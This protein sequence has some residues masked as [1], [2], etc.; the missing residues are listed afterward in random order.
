LSLMSNA[1]F[2]SGPYTFA[3]TGPNGFVS[4][5]ENPVISNVTE[6]YNGT[7]DL[8]ITDAN[9]CVGTGNL[10][11]SGITNA[12]AQPVISTDGVICDGGV[13]QLSIAAYTGSSVDYAWIVPSS[14]N[15]TGINTNVL[16]INPVDSAIHEGNYVVTVT[17]DGCMITSDT[18]NLELHP[19]PSAAPT[20]TP[21]PMC[22]GEELNLTANGTG[23]S[24]YFWT[25]PNGFTSN[26][27][28]PV[29]SNI[30]IANNGTY[31]L[32]VTNITGCSTT[33]E[34]VVSNI[35]G[36]PV[37]P[38]ITAV[39]TVCTD[40]V[41]TLSIQQQYSGAV[42]YNWTNGVGVTIGT[43]TTVTLSPNSIFAISPYRV[44]VTVNGC[45]SLLSDPVEVIEESLP[46]AIATNGG[47]IC[48]GADGQLFA[49]PITGATYEWRVAGTAT[50]ISTAQNPIIPN[51]QDSTTFELT[52]TS[53]NGCVSNPLSYTEIPV[54]TAPTANPN[55]SYSVN[56]D[57]TPSD[58]TLTA[59]ATGAGLLYTW[60]G[61][62]G[63]TSNAEN[64]IIPNASSANN[65][66]YTLT[67]TTEN[68]CV[69]IGVT[70]VLIDIT[71]Q[72]AQ[73]IIA[74]SGP[75]CEGETIVLTVPQY[76]G[77]NVNYT[78]TTPSGT[79]T[80]I[81]GENT[82]EIVISP[83]NTVDHQ[84]TYTLTVTVDGCTLTSDN[85]NVDV[86]DVP[87]AT[88]S[89]TA[90]GICEGDGLEL[91]S[92]GT[93]V[94]NLTYAWV[95]PN[96]FTSTL[97]NPNINTTT[98]ANNGQYTVTVT[99]ISGCS[100]VESIMV[101][102]ILP[103]PDMPTIYADA[104]ICEGDDLIL[105]TSAN[106]VTFE[107]IG[108]L[109]ASQGTL[110]LPGLTT[111]SSATI[112][113]MS[114][115]SYLSGEWQVQ[116]TDANGC[117]VISEAMAVT[118]NEIPVAFATN[119][120]M[121]C[122]EESVQLF[123]GT[124]QGAQYRWFNDDPSASPAP[125]LI[126]TEQN[127]VIN[128]LPAGTHD[129]Y[130]HVVKNN[131]ESAI[132]SKTTVTVNEQPVIAA[133][134]GTGSYCQGSDIIL[135]AT[136]SSNISGNINYTWTGPNGFSYT[137][138]IGANGSFDVILPNVSPDMEGTYTLTLES[139]SGCI[140]DVQSVN[141][142]LDAT[143]VTPLLQAQDDNLCEGQDLEL[144]TTLYTGTPV[145]YE[146]FFDDG[147][148]AISIA[149]TTVPT[150][151]VNGVTPAND[152]VYYVQTTVDGCTSSP[153]NVMNVQIFGAFTAPDAGNSTSAAS[154]ACEGEFVQLNVPFFVGATYEWYGPNGFNSSMANPVI[155]PV[156]TDD[157][158]D[159]YAVITLDNNCTVMVTAP[160]YVFIQPQPIAPTITNN[161]SICEGGDFVLSVSSPLNYPPGTVFNFDW[162]FAPTN[163]LVGSSTD[164]NFTMT[165]VLA[166]DSGNY[167]V[168]MTIGNCAAEASEVTTVQVDF[169]PPN[170]ADAGEDTELCATTTYI[171]DGEMPTIGTGF[172]TSTTGATVSNPELYNSEV[173]DLIEGENIFVWTLS[174]GACENYDS[175]TVIITV[176]LIPVDVAFAGQDFSICGDSGSS[177]NANIPVASAGMWTQPS[178]QASLGVV[179]ENPTSPTS[180]ILGLMP[181]NTYEFTWSLSQGVCA[182]F[183][184]DEVL[185]TTFEAPT[186][187]AFIAEN[188]VYT[189]GDDF[190]N[191]SA[192]VP[193]V[194]GG[195][196]TTNSGATI[197]EPD[198]AS[199]IVADLQEGENMFVWTLS[200][201]AC[202][203]YSSDT[204]YVYLEDAEIEATADDY[205]LQFEEVLENEDLM[206]NDFV[207]NID[208][209]EISVIEAPTNGSIT[210][211]ED[212]LFSYE[213]NESFFGV[214]VFIYQICNV[215]CPNICDTASVTIRVVG[216]ESSGECWVPNVITPNNDNLNDNFV[217][218]CLDVYPNA[219][220]C[221]FNRWGDR[222]M[223][224]SPY[225]NDWN[226]TYKGKDLA[227]GTYFYVLQP[228]PDSD[229]MLQ[230]YFN[231]VR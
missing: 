132:A 17:V 136:N 23:A 201:G 45:A 199:T 113:P 49:N 209:W 104:S 172:W 170:A 51:L 120:G 221:I 5:L 158:G 74:S 6:E 152:G 163:T 94:G 79:F 7:F 149:I 177:L 86:F 140:S 167:Y 22:E 207:G 80:N 193:S 139:N 37:T 138:T 24:T 153:S 114:S 148:G 61:P 67:V 213:P 75:T 186:V 126:S 46:A 161:S 143:P 77:S 98:T 89:A 183:A 166:T 38:V 191:I 81:T 117:T 121:I 142:D 227:P 60:T 30:T 96:G 203:N 198:F 56:A 157:I 64:P 3:W 218:P 174:S 73:P 42:A 33:T 69:V 160:T 150:F 9:G 219:R 144:N 182:D 190:L 151:F 173:I 107:W 97:A 230:G 108:P 169:I 124:V 43:G 103:T 196:W 176:N 220:L 99:S 12:I 91:V 210:F 215:N 70:N 41:F 82:N 208:E 179:I 127:P 14:D 168:V 116:V 16:T 115:Q 141:V 122:Q 200:N 87:T 68:E 28:N 88:P 102:N 164:P 10:Q 212:G 19:T 181:G 133:I 188:Q 214:D 154:P 52:V 197:V 62:N 145:S 187:S 231:I 224:E 123:A 217:I 40:D 48:A 21:T 204:L 26:A 13:V 15:V 128:N 59:N 223:E 18:F 29:L 205:M 131:C 50:I 155:N 25:G 55:A 65:G 1:S 222:V 8:T 165:N 216:L 11:V 95:G 66:A 137:S 135:T 118:I 36:T 184:S 76:T 195:T 175:D 84:G 90:G 226:G 189:C 111:N 171:L 2:G 202:G 134:A 194:G 100:A 192:N 39:N 4:S 180:E 109:G 162:Y 156:T 57:C 54:H 211:F 159:Y 85:Y 71:N 44:T 106:G 119:S 130:L 53:A 225:N 31:T 112:L 105:T 34:I 35:S 147:T 78:W 228:D 83:V 178:I 93:G 72:V 27:E 58:L 229:E 125:D 185:V 146:W 20:S 92:A 129:F 206:I 32:T 101:N 47:D 110:A 63:F